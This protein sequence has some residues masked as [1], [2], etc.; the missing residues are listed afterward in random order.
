MKGNFDG[1]HW[2]CQPFGC[3]PI[4][5]IVNGRPMAVHGC[6]MVAIHII[7]DNVYHQRWQDAQVEDWPKL[8]G[9]WFCCKCT[10]ESFMAAIFVICGNG[11]RPRWPPKVS[12]P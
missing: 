6:V 4:S 1:H 8:N 7:F 9:V 10:V 12:C 11:S 5:K 3:Q 2:Y